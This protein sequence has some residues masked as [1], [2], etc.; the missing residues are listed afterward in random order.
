MVFS[1]IYPCDICYDEN[2]FASVEHA[3]QYTKVKTYGHDDPTDQ[4]RKA[5]DGKEA[6]KLARK[7]MPGILKCPDQ[8]KRLY[9][10]RSHFPSFLASIL[11]PE[12]TLCTHPERYPGL[13]ML[14]KIFM[15]EREILLSLITFSANRGRAKDRRRT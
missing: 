1:N 14:R 9:S 5:K 8:V 10:S 7:V 6:L 2:T 15:D 13:D 12:M 11:G 4:I 3:Y